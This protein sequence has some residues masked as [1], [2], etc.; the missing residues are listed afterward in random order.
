MHKA[1]SKERVGGKIRSRK[2]GGTAKFQ[3]KCARGFPWS[4]LEFLRQDLKVETWTNLTLG[5]PYSDQGRS[6]TLQYRQPRNVEVEVDV[7]VLSCVSEMGW[8]LLLI[9]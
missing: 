9:M 3:C 1:L 8:A 6:Y 5:V 4:E 2:R 7:D